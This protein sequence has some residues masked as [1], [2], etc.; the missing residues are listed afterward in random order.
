ME[1]SVTELAPIVPLC[2]SWSIG[3]SMYFTT[4]E[5]E[6]CRKQG[7]D[8]STSALESCCWWVIKS[9]VKKFCTIVLINFFW[10]CEILA[11]I[12]NR[13]WLNGIE[14]SCGMLGELS[15]LLIFLLKCFY[16]TLLCHSLNSSY[17]LHVDPKP[18]LFFYSVHF[19]WVLSGVFLLFSPVRTNYFDMP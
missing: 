8:W 18:T 9:L 14:I 7:S 3:S 10:P 11:L 12:K 17:H 2:L 16:L 19:E 6:G 4:E 1:Q 15:N 5:Q 13:T